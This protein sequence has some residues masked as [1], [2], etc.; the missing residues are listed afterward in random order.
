M[1]MG[2]LGGKPTGLN[3]MNLN[4][5]QPTAAP[6]LPGQMPPGVRTNSAGMFNPTQMSGPVVP[7]GLGNQSQLFNPNARSGTTAAYNAR[8]SASG[9]RR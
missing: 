9:I 1:S 6:R 7:Q 3:T 2:G 8:A 4:K 5:V